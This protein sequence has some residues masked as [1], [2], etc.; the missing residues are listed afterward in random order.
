[1]QGTV[2]GGRRRGRQK[3][4]WDD[5]IR[6]WT[7]LEL[8]NTLRKA[9]DREEW[10][11]VVGRSS[12]VP[13]RIP[14]LRD[15]DY[16]NEE[17]NHPPS[18]TRNLKKS[19]AKRL[20]NNSSNAEIFQ[21]AAEKYQEALTCSGYKQQPRYTPTHKTLTHTGASRANTNLKANNESGETTNTI[22]CNYQGTPDI[23]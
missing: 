23:S 13:R 10:K 3:K 6:E 2:N 17:S 14:N 5:N 11:A 15:S 8:R 12:A 20:S 18:T 7:G 21:Q 22:T 1:M 9:E 4:R 16:I 19:I